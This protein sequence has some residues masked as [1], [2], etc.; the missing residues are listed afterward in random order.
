MSSPATGRADR[1]WL[2][3]LLVRMTFH[4][5]PPMWVLARCRHASQ[6]WRGVFS[7][8]HQRQEHARPELSIRRIRLEMPGR[9]LVLARQE[10]TD[11]MSYGV[12]LPGRSPAV[13]SQLSVGRECSQERPSH[14]HSSQDSPGSSARRV[15]DE[16]TTA[17]ATY[18]ILR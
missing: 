4:V 5:S 7:A 3:P 16:T 2:S 11:S 6:I 15:I 14:A 13:P 17:K 12:K 9:K 18:P 8:N 10:F 1:G